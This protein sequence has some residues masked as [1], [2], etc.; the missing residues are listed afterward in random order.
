MG[1]GARSWLGAA[2][3]AASL[4]ALAYA[5]PD[6]D[7]G[8]AR[9]AEAD[10][11]GAL[12]A[13]E[14][15]EESPGLSRAELASLLEGRALV[16]YALG[17]RDALARDLAE[18]AV[19]EGAH[20][21]RDDAPPDVVEAY[22]RARAATRPVRVVVRPR[23]LADRVELSAEALDDTQGLVRRVE[24][25]ARV[26][27]RWEQSDTGA[28]EVEGRPRTIEVV[29]RAVGPGG[30]VLAHHGR[31]DAP[32]LVRLSGDA[33]PVE[34]GWIGLGIGVAVAVGVIVTIVVLATG[35]SGDT[36]VVGPSCPGCAVRFD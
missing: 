17:D 36:I 19:V 32:E 1:T 30:V 26:H 27:G 21:F 25:F 12:T 10:F 31:R 34:W 7:R 13:F 4:P 8:M 18:L 16:H 9:Y 11:E 6:V 23:A 3:V 20:R 22:V 5:H 29:A 15:A 28:L 24:L 33:E 35:E 2:L 14:R